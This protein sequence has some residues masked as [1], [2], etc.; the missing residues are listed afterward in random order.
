MDDTLY[1]EHCRVVPINDGDK[2][3]LGCAQEITDR[4]AEEYKERIAVERGLY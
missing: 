4:L 1:C 3:C 2:Y